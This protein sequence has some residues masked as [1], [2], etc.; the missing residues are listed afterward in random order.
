MGDMYNQNCIIE[1]SQQQ[2]IKSGD[3]NKSI[4]TNKLAEPILINKHDKISVLN[5]FVNV[6]GSNSET[7]N[8][9]N[10]NNKIV[11]GKTKLTIS[12]YKTNNGINCVPMPYS[13]HIGA[14]QNNQVYY[15][16]EPTNIYF[17]EDLGQNG[18]NV[19][20]APHNLLWNLTSIGTGGVNDTLSHRGK[21]M[22]GI[23]YNIAKSY[24]KYSNSAAPQ[25]LSTTD[26]AARPL[27]QFTPQI[28]NDRYTAMNIP[29]PNGEYKIMTEEIEIDI[30]EGFYSPSN[31]AELVTEA[32]TSPTTTY[33]D[34]ETNKKSGLIETSP[35]MTLHNG[36]YISYNNKNSACNMSS[37]LCLNR[38]NTSGNEF[39]IPVFMPMQEV[40]YNYSGVTTI[41]QALYTPAE[42][43]STRPS[44][45]WNLSNNAVHTDPVYF[46][47]PNY[48]IAG[49]NLM[50]NL[51]PLEEWGFKHTPGDSFGDTGNYVLTRLYN[52]TNLNL[53]KA[54]FDAQEKD[55]VLENQNFQ[56]GTGGYTGS[57]MPG[58]IDPATQRFLILVNK[59]FIT[60]TGAGQ[61]ADNPYVNADYPFGNDYT[62]MAGDGVNAYPAYNSTQFDARSIYE[63]DDLL[64][65][66]FFT[67]PTNWPQILNP[68][69]QQLENRKTSRIMDFQ[70]LNT[71]HCA[72][73]QPI[74]FNPAD[75][76]NID[77]GYGFATPYYD[78][79]TGKNYIQISITANEGGLQKNI[80]QVGIVDKIGWTEHFSTP[81]NEAIMQVQAYGA[82]LKGAKNPITDTTKT[83]DSTDGIIPNSFGSTFK[84]SIIGSPNAL[85]NFDTAR[86]RF[87]FSNF[88]S[89]LLI[90]NPF[91][92]IVPQGQTYNEPGD[93]G[94]EI[95]TLNS[96]IANQI[97]VINNV[98]RDLILHGTTRLTSNFPRLNG[99]NHQ[100]QGVTQTTY[101]QD[102]LILQSDGGIFIESFI[103]NDNTGITED[104]S[105]WPNCLWDTLGFNYLPLH[106]TELIYSNNRQTINK[107]YITGI[108]VPP[109]SS[110]ITTNTIA[111]TTTNDELVANNDN[112]IQYVNGLM[113]N[114][115]TRNIVGTSSLIIADNLPKKEHTA[116]YVICSDIVNNGISCYWSQS[117]NTLNAVDTCSLSFNSSDYF[118]SSNNLQHEVSNS[119]VLS[120]ITTQL[121]GPDGLIA[122]SDGSSSVVYLVQRTINKGLTEEQIEENLNIQQNLIKN[123]KG[124]KEIDAVLAAIKLKENV[125]SLEYTKRDKREEDT[126]IENEADELED[127]IEK[128]ETKSAPKEEGEIRTAEIPQDIEDISADDL[129]GI[130]G[131][132]NLL[133]EGETGQT[134]LRGNVDNLLLSDNER[135][136]ILYDLTMN[137]P[138]PYQRAAIGRGVRGV[139]NVEGRREFRL[140]PVGDN[141]KLEGNARKDFNDLVNIRLDELLTGNRN[142]T[143]NFHRR[144]DVYR[145]AEHLEN[146]IRTG[147]NI[148]NFSNTDGYDNL[149]RGE[150][151]R[152]N[153]LV[154]TTT[155]DYNYDVNS[156][157][158][159][160]LD[161]QM[162]MNRTYSTGSAMSSVFSYDPQTPGRLEEISKEPDLDLDE[163][164]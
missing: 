30:E 27:S 159:A 152:R 79:I 129:L 117:N 20:N 73:I 69:T 140:I 111:D 56:K 7:I 81:G 135:T 1:C 84:K 66:D 15:D 63:L 155:S 89:P 87:E 124:F 72:V 108:K 90:G 145:F 35:T 74:Q 132:Y 4:W 70:C 102:P 137:T 96:R 38:K 47:N 82:S 110:P 36:L 59:N 43:S 99:F 60:F 34:D 104:I 31:I 49:Q 147:N 22:Q 164:E 119:Y 13:W 125:S 5:A 28:S 103:K 77:N 62:G 120:S 67:A 92:P 61:T 86:S 2:A 40:F 131:R 65:N 144:P 57:N 52:E 126:N 25:P 53:F 133:E 29:Q 161:F 50:N 149:S 162:E 116:Y 78:S 141:Y 14:L 80:N 142:N 154:R 33:V 156:D 98:D 11:N 23:T 127:E 32:L 44:Y 95:F 58:V 19:I 101:Q 128:Q 39:T 42:L 109:I 123:N 41:N 68:D 3:T 136:D 85:L 75:K 12:F 37:P 18:V 54:F 150:R 151:G 160:P 76:D 17:T 163:D 115:F 113:N 121:R 112:L 143:T 100:S 130:Q 88:H 107:D 146:Q 158:I 93:V 64:N 118:F 16:T 21:C 122:K 51:Q 105:N 71:Q 138:I 153:N 48:I 97:K 157:R 148:Q 6:R 46:R 10:N 45:K 55:G 94:T 24:K 139:R 9:I 26:S 91:T 106:L 8:I 134:F 83:I 114:V